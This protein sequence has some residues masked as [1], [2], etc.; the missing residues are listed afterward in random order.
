MT[1]ALAT[2]PYYLAWLKA[3]DA[4]ILE[5]DTTY[6][7][8]EARARLPERYLT[9]IMSRLKTVSIH[10]FFNINGALGLDL[11][12]FENAIATQQ[13]KNSHEFEA[14]KAKRRL[15]AGGGKHKSVKIVLS[16]D[17]LHKIAR[18]GGYARAAALTSA[19]R[20]TIARKAARVRWQNGAGRGLAS[21][22]G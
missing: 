12:L 10:T 15:K 3:V 17:F 11:R 16:P 18:D 21:P 9:K 13:L 6:S 2:A 4:R 7:V 8:I 20:S 19:R 5:L 22:A 1:D 14:R